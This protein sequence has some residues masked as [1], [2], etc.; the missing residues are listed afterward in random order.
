MSKKVLILTGDAVEALEV[1]YPYYRCLEEGFDVTIASPAVKKLYTVSH[2]FI[3]GLETYVERP[4]YNLDSHA[5]LADID[6]EQFDGLIIPGGRAPEYIR[7][8]EAVPAILRHFFEKNK[9]VGAICHAALMLEVIPDV[10]KGREYT[11][12]PACKPDVLACGATYIDQNL[13]THKNLVSG[14]AW[15]D[16]PGFMREFIRLLK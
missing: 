7:M 6:P 3:E 16:L 8:N 2:D 15:P 10:M 13:H 11:A 12:Y 14:K 5:A 9:P 1:F 4:A